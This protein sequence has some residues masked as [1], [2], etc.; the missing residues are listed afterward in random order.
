[1]LDLPYEKLLEIQQSI[2]IL[3]N[4]VAVFSQRQGQR[5]LQVFNAETPPVPSHDSLKTITLRQL[6]EIP[7]RDLTDFDGLMVGFSALDVIRADLV[8]K[9]PLFSPLDQIFIERGETAVLNRTLANLSTE[10]MRQLREEG[11]QA[12]G[13]N[14]QRAEARALEIA[15]PFMLQERDCENLVAILPIGEMNRFISKKSCRFVYFGQYEEASSAGQTAQSVFSLEDFASVELDANNWVI[16]M[17]EAA[18]FNPVMRVDTPRFLDLRRVLRST[19]KEKALQS[20]RLGLARNLLD[21]QARARLRGLLVEGSQPFLPAARALVAEY[22]LAESELE[23]LV[24]LCPHNDF[25][26]FMQTGDAVRVY[27][28]L[29]DGDVPLE[30]SLGPA[31]SLAKLVKDGLP[32]G[33]GETIFTFPMVRFFLRDRSPHNYQPLNDLFWKI[34]HIN[35]LARSL[36]LLSYDLM[37]GLCGP[38]PGTQN[39]LE[40]ALDTSLRACTL[41]SLYDPWRWRQ[42]RWRVYLEGCYHTPLTLLRRAAEEL[43]PAMAHY[44]RGISDWYECYSEEKPDRRLRDMLERL[45][46]FERR[47]RDRQQVNSELRV[48]LVQSRQL[49]EIGEALLRLPFSNMLIENKNSLAV[50]SSQRISTVEGIR[51]TANFAE[52]LPLLS[53]FFKQAWEFLLKKR[54]QRQQLSSR[55]RDIDRL[56]GQLSQLLA[57]L[58]RE[59]RALFAPAHELNILSFAFRLEIEHIE[60]LLRELETAA[61]L[62]LNLRNPWVDLHNEV[63][64]TLEISNIGRVGAEGVE[65]ILELGRGIQLLDESTIREFP[66]LYPGEAKQIHYRIRTI[67]EDAELRLEYSFHDRRGQN[68]KDT[69]INHLVVRNMD[70]EPYQVKVNR[71]QFGRPIQEPTEFYGRRAELQNILSQLIAGGKQNLLLRGPRRMGKTSLLYMLSRAITEPATRRFFNLPDG[72][73]EYLDLVHPIFLSMHSFNLTEGAV[74]AEQFF[75]TLLEKVAHAVNLPDANLNWAL[76]VYQQRLRDVGVVNAALEQVDQVLETAPNERIAVLLDEYDEVYR[77][78]T[79]NL[80]RHLRE[81][82]SAEQRLTWIISSTLALFREVKTISSPW[83]N[84]FSILELTR[85]TEDAAV[86]LVEIPCKEEKVFWRSDAVLA[87]LGETGRHPAFTQL[88]CA[89]VIAYLNR[90]HTNYVLEETILTVAEEIIGEQET[91][92]SHFEFYWTDTGGI[93]RLILLIL[94][95][96]DT[97]LSRKEVQR[98]V[99]SRLRVKFGE[100]PSQ[101]MKEP[102]GDTLEWQE[103]EFKIGIDFVEKIVNAITL[104]DQRRYVFSVPLFRRWLRRLRRYQDLMAETYDTIGQEMESDGITFG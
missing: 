103:R 63:D 13:S 102:S 58:R 27:R 14:R 46:D 69:W 79:G 85:L 100:L 25:E 98:R 38:M 78:E 10:I 89:R 56:T 26:H 71:Y 16:A 5:L 21:L 72:W 104:D 41:Y 8:T 35:T 68:H 18:L 90:M 32:E 87:L 94:D 54:Y 82:V 91:A 34:G 45:R 52:P 65:I 44:Y 86:A 49:I 37:N 47:V 6:I 93:G 2:T 33:Y 36:W 75:R 83:F 74:A 17:E 95:D 50:D 59:M 40:I 67:R 29:E 22:W 9:G 11:E 60:T 92:T 55:E 99:I 61:M 24:A 84:V 48:S 42:G 23:D 97:P 28:V 51:R 96:S 101:R 19:G 66:V 15:L 64:L 12:A 62:A 43:D 81:F 39:S 1:M 88:F 7:E 30:R 20:T 31:I 53:P 4:L 3:D 80:D 70:E 57:S 76:E 77:P 73:D